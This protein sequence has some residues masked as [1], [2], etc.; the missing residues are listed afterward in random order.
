M[1]M[2]SAQID[3]S[4]KM[5]RWRR[6]SLIQRKKVMLPMDSDEGRKCDFTPSCIHSILLRLCTGRYVANN[7]MFIEMACMLWAFDFLPGKDK[8][9]HIQLPDPTD[10]DNQG[11][12]V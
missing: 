4:I 3:I 9:G 7:T 12:V 5:A 10:C 2:I 6:L 11:L 8:D 1:P